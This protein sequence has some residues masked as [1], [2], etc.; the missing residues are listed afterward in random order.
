[1][2]RKSASGRSKSRWRR[3]RKATAHNCAQLG[4]VNNCKQKCAYLDDQ[5][6][7]RLKRIAYI[8]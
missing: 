8:G 4:M 2:A 1:V 3:A 6:Y 7:G 5:F